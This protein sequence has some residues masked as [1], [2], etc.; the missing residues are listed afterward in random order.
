MPRSGEDADVAG[1]CLDCRTIFLLPYAP[2]DPG[3]AGRIA[4]AGLCARC[5]GL[6]VALDA[7]EQHLAE[8]IAVLRA[9]S[10]LRFATLLQLVESWDVAPPSPLAAVAELGPVAPA[11]LAVFDVRSAS[12]TGRRAVGALLMQVLPALLHAAVGHDDPAAAAHT[13]LAGCVAADPRALSA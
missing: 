9:A 13:I 2:G 5:G 6:V 10:S 3:I 1:A 11:V 12:S 8:V 7:A 4:A